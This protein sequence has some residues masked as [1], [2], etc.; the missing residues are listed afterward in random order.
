MYYAAERE[1]P[2]LEAIIDWFLWEQ[3][4]QGFIVSPAPYSHMDGLSIPVSL[5]QIRGYRRD[6]VILAARRALDWMLAA[7]NFQT[8]WDVDLHLLLARCE[9]LAAGLQVLPDHEFASTKWR[10]AWSLDMWRAEGRV[11]AGK[12]P[13]GVANGSGSWL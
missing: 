9:T 5:S 11:L 8:L 12:R 2:N 6:D 13:N 10:R 7:D 3:D 4:E 1:I